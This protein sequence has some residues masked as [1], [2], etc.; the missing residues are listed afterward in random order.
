MEGRASP[1]R[2]HPHSLFFPPELWKAGRW[3][4]APEPLC[5]TCVSLTVALLGASGLVRVMVYRITRLWFPFSS[6][7][8]G[9][10]MISEG[11]SESREG[12]KELWCPTSEPAILTV[13]RPG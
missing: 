7:F 9:W 10:K 4:G 2:R 6:F 13:S 3:A 1:W 12:R 8:Q 5:L 11:S